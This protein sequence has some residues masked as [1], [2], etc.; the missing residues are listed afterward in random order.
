MQSR[1]R[2]NSL[3]AKSNSLVKMLVCS[4]VTPIPVLSLA[5]LQQVMRKPWLNTKLKI[6]T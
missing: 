5:L 4:K 2:G 6:N 3:A 1:D